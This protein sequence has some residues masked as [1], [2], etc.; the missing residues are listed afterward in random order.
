MTTDYRKQ[1]FKRKKAAQL[2][3]Y[4]SMIISDRFN[5]FAKHME[6]YHKYRL[7]VHIFMTSDNVISDQ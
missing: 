6:K 3:S 7:K 5:Y 2:N 1:K 4:L